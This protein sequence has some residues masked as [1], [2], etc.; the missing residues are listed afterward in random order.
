MHHPVPPIPRRQRGIVLMVALV[1]LLVITLLAIMTLG[2]ATTEQRIAA[3]DQFRNMGFQGAESAIEAAMTNVPHLSAALLSPTPVDL[4][5]T[6]GSAPVTAA[7][8]TSYLGDASNIVGYSM[9]SGSPLAAYHFLIQGTGTVNG[10]N[11][12]AVTAQGIYRIAP[13][14]GG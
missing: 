7:A 13:A 11:L 10:V 9:G 5:V 3:T 6:L 14:E 2:S 1:M 12:P 8:R 4:T